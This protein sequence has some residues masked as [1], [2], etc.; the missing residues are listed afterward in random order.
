MI[1]NFNRELI[2]K[3]FRIKNKLNTIENP[4]DD[5]SIVDFV[6]DY[7]AKDIRNHLIKNIKTYNEEKSLQ[8]LVLLNII[9]L[10]VKKEGINPLDIE[11]FKLIVNFLIKDPNYYNYGIVTLHLFFNRFSEYQ[12]YLFI[13]KLN[14]EDKKYLYDKIV[15]GLLVDAVINPNLNDYF[16]KIKKIIDLKHINIEKLS[17]TDLFS[18]IY[19]WYIYERQLEPLNDYKNTFFKRLDNNIETLFSKDDLFTIL[20]CVYLLYYDPRNDL[21]VKIDDFIKK[22][23]EKCED[24]LKISEFARYLKEFSRNHPFFK[25]FLDTLINVIDVLEDRNEIV[26]LGVFLENYNLNSI[27]HIDL[28]KKIRSK[29]RIYVE[30]GIYDEINRVYLNIDSIIQGKINQNKE[31]DILLRKSLNRLSVIT[32]QDLDSIKSLLNTNWKQ[33]K[34]VDGDIVLNQQLSL[35]FRYLGFEVIPIEMIMH[36]EKYKSLT[37]T[38]HPDVILYDFSLN[39][40]VIIEEETKLDKTVLYKKETIK[41]LIDI[42]APLFYDTNKIIFQYLAR[43]ISSGIEKLDQPPNII[44]QKE[45]VALLSQVFGEILLVENIFKN[46]ELKENLKYCIDII[47]GDISLQY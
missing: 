43:T 8:C 4:L 10:N 16:E 13:N 14:E 41:L 40:I 31:M 29:I 44:P 26:Y 6:R 35:L 21:F 2:S 38:I 30:M 47:K 33:I 27:E 5:S 37:Q 1:I 9:I 39:L 32:K 18:K 36:N 24:I 42:F 15:N 25:K 23:L 45:F 11:N 17:Y 3:I 34:I 7:P 19:F 12:I 20:K 46:D 28:L 22:K